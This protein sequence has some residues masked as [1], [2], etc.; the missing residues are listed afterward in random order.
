ML[1]KDDV[2]AALKKVKYPGFS[3]D[4]VSFGVVKELSLE[5]GKV[6]FVLDLPT[7]KEEVAQELTRK[8][9][10]ALRAMPGVVDIEMEVRKKE[11]Q[12]SQARGGDPWANRAPIP[13]VKRTIAVASGKGGVGKSTVAVNLAVALAKLGYKTGLCDADVYGPSLPTILNVNEKPKVL[14]EDLLVPVQKHG[15]K[16][17]SIGFLV[18]DDT[19]VIWRGPMVMQ[20]VTQFLKKV[21]WGVLD[22]LVIDLP[23]GTGDAQLTLVQSIPLT[24]AV[25][26]TTPSDVALIDA[27]RG[28]RM[29]EQ[30]NTPVLGLVE[31]MSFFLCPHCGKETDIFSKGGARRVAGEIGVPLLGE[32]PL[33]AAINFGTDKGEPVVLSQPDG[34]LGKAFMDLARAVIQ[35]ADERGVDPKPSSAKVIFTQKA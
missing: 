20:L 3:R 24:G 15:L 33:D 14:G 10:E 5:G 21:A 6:C 23:P 2:L 22:Y 28:L 25:I 7:D 17:M 29:F 35:A 13:G 16:L 26:V 19:P 27:R 32:I 11:A 9:H 31:N 8:V 18:E 4:I 30:V 1:T 34:P 12:P